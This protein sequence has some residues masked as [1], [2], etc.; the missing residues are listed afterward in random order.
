MQHNEHGV[1][2][3]DATM[4]D[5][6]Y[7][8]HATSNTARPPQFHLNSRKFQPELTISAQNFG[9]YP[10]QHADP[11]LGCICTAIGNVR[12]NGFLRKAE[13]VMENSV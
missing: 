1:N 2:A 10:G 9:L 3:V 13:K 8:V 11:G 5:D 12:P 6:G 4:S 7:R